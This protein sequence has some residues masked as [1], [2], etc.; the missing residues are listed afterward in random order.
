MKRKTIY[1]TLV[2]N[3]NP[4]VAGDY[5][6]RGLRNAAQISY[7]KCSLFYRV[8]DAVTFK[9]A[10]ELCAVPDYEITILLK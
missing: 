1:A 3:E 7:P 9:D 5:L 8:G 10:D 2:P 6:I 4:L